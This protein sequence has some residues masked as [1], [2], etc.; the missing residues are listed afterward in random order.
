MTDP[1]PIIK[2]GHPTIQP[3][4]GPLQVPTSCKSKDHI[5]LILL[6]NDLMISIIDDVING[7]VSLG[8]VDNLT[9]VQQLVER[10]HVNL[11]YLA[12]LHDLS[13]S[14]LEPRD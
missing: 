7:Y 14:E 11:C 8:P 2:Q 10:L 4:R 3:D 13:S 1:V 6:E 5:D 12:A 9:Q